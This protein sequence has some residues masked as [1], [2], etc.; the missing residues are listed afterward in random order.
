MIVAVVAVRVMKM[1]GDAVIH[2]VPVR[3]RLVPAAGAVHV[4]RVMPTAAM[5]GGTAL[6]VFA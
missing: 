4:A 3:Y 6:G 5:V 1:P 2:V